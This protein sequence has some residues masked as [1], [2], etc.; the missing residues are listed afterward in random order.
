MKK[1][2][3]LP[4]LFLA[5]AMGTSFIFTEDQSS[6]QPNT[7]SKPC[8]ECEICPPCKAKCCTDLV[9][10]GEPSNC[11]YNAP[12][13]IDPAC[14][15]DAWFSGSFLYWQPRE[16]GMRLGYHN[17][18]SSSSAIPTYKK[19]SLPLAF[20]F[21][22]AFK[23][24]LGFSSERDDWTIFFEYTRFYSEDYRKK[25]I[26]ESVSGTNF[27]TTPWIKSEMLSFANNFVSNG[28]ISSLSG[29][30]K[31]KLNLIDI[32]IARPFYLGK[33]L[34][35]NPYFGLRGGSIGQKYKLKA[36]Y[37]NIIDKVNYV[38][39]YACDT[40]KTWLIGPRTGVDTSWLIGCH[41]RVFGNVASSLCYQKFKPKIFQKLPF[42]PLITKADVILYKDRD[43]KSATYLTPNLELEAGVGY[44]RYFFNNEW[45]FDL[46]MG[47]T[48]QYFW[49]QNMIRQ[50]SDESSTISYGDAGNLMFHGLTLTA[51]LD[52]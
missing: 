19:N 6:S 3:S 29:N 26:E 18:E 22:P 14:G 40:L 42:Q 46:S 44:G 36:K 28:Q 47:Y 34:I 11:A 24:G 30:W 43:I 2:L 45:Y 7:T 49:G 52:F 37:V 41:F 25:N 38:N 23:V 39:I 33:K 21:H 27:L 9:V 4:L 31:T 1:K 10:I 17:R 16:K 15:W 50:L 5:F 20:D 48:F 13:R 35:F 32:E 8:K 51:R 12:A